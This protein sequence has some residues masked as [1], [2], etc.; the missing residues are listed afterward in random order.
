MSI[1]SSRHF[2]AELAKVCGITEELK[3]TDQLRWVVEMNNVKAAEEIVFKK[4]IY[5]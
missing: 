4:I 3:A 1:P 5:A 2:T